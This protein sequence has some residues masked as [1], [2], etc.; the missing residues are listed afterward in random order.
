MNQFHQNYFN[1]GAPMA[2][3]TSSASPP[4]P[5]QKKRRRQ[6]ITGN[7]TKFFSLINKM[8]NAFNKLLNFIDTINLT[9]FSPFSKQTMT[10]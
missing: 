4:P 1:A 9:S 7:Y 8:I 3:T 10:M 2:L 5:A 6:Q